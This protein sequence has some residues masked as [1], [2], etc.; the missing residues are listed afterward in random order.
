MLLPAGH[1]T[2]ESN[3]KSRNM[4]Y[5]RKSFCSNRFILEQDRHVM[6]SITAGFNSSLGGFKKIVFPWFLG[7]NHPNLIFTVI[8]LTLGGYSL[9]VGVVYFSD[10]LSY[11]TSLNPEGA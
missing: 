3:G 11:K 9:L 1:S 7:F 2:A 10:C 8:L 6:E 4:N 5:V